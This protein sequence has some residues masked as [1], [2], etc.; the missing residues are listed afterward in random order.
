MEETET[1]CGSG[2]LDPFTV[3]WIRTRLQIRKQIR[4]RILEVQ[5]DTDPT[6]PDP[7]P[8]L[9]HWF[10]TYRIVGYFVQLWK[11][12]RIFKI[13]VGLQYKYML[14]HKIMFKTFVLI[15]YFLLDIFLNDLFNLNRPSVCLFTDIYRILVCSTTVL[16][17]YCIILPIF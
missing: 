13:F 9:E 7:A 1:A 10:S 14:E 17:R 2:S 11:Q 8:D 4:I 6:D 3:L 12:Q 15:L 16:Q 5:N